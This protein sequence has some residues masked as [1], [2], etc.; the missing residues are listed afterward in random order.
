[1]VE[2]G[3]ILINNF[4][5]FPS[6]EWQPIADAVSFAFGAWPTANPDVCVDRRR[7]A[8]PLPLGSRKG[9]ATASRVSEAN[10][11]PARPARNDSGPGT[12]FLSLKRG[13]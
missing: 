12:P 5:G 11:S 7:I 9:M 10:N 2:D 3:I 4:F 13:R 6:T 1:M 8:I